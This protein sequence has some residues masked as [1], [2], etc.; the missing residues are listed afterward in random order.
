MRTETKTMKKI[1]LMY[2]QYGLQNDVVYHKAKK[3]LSVYRDVVWAANQGV[4][5]MLFESRLTYGRDLD[6]ALTYLSDFAPTEKQ[7]E[8]EERVT[9]LFETKWLIDL[10]DKAMLKVCDY[11]TNGRLYHEILSDCYITFL[12]CSETEL[13]TK[14]SMERSTFYEKKKE[15]VMLLGIALWGYAIPELKGMYESCNDT[16]DNIPAYFD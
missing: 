12:P 16:A 8:F 11:H 9:C 7:Q 14:L 3:V 10:I 15:A 2:N 5:D 4:D 1:R 6:I 13:L